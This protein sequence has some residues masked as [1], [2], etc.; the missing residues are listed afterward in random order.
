MAEVFFLVTTRRES[1]KLET[2]IKELLQE[3]EQ[4]QE[5]EEE[6]KKET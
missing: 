1:W 5:E 4:E 2:T 3:Q 6:R